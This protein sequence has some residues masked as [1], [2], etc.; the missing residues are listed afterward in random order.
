MTLALLNSGHP[1]VGCVGCFLTFFVP[2]RNNRR[3]V[4]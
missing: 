2:T 4:R 1:I 3:F